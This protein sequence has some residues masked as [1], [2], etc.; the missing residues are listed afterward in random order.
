MIGSEST[1]LVEVALPLKVQ[2]T[3]T[4]EVPP[5]MRGLAV[6]G[7]RAL[8]PLGDRR[9]TGYI[10]G[11]AT[12]APHAPLKAIHNLL[13]PE[14]LLDGHMLELTRWAAEYY[15]TSWGLVIRTSLPPGID[16]STAR[17][18]EL[19]GSPEL[20]EVGEHELKAVCLNLRELFHCSMVTNGYHEPSCR[21]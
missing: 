18:V 8:V 2:H 15:L 12:S 1:G 17:I 6:A 19:I 9:M 4:Y 7:V 11:M 5:A 13:D 3:F 16:R 14:P 20:L 21:T 10:V